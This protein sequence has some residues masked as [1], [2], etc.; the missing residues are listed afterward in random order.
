MNRT[1]W[2]L[3]TLATLGVIGSWV[4]VILGPANLDASAAFS[5]VFGGGDGPTGIIVR[6][7][8]LPRVG[9]TLVAGAG[10]GAAGAMLQSAMRNP[11][12]DPQIFGIGGG[13]AIV[14]ALAIAGVV[15]L[16][17]WGLISLSVVASLGVAAVITLFAIREGMTPARLALV[18][19]SVGA[20]SLAITTA[21]LA[22][23]RVVSSQALALVGGSLANRGWD[24]WIPALTWLFVGTVIAVVISGRINLLALGDNVAANLGAHPR[25]TR[26]AA[27]AAA[28]ILSGA[29]V[30]I[31]GLIGFVGLLAPHMT[32]WLAGHD[33]RTLMLVS[34]PLGAVL[35]LYSDQV[36]RLAVA[37]S[38][39][40]VGLVATVLGA[41]VMIY[42]AR[43]VT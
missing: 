34:P 27:M 17:P 24:S 39:L 4:G 14:Q 41:P 43:W 42:V 19:I 11:L 7:I 12:G 13:A 36:A 8:R 35:T 37:P 23:S 31:A 33:T 32:R 5:A 6:E 1:G 30:T 15:T 25:S 28:G 3:L 26:A 2:L 18:G 40:P 16:G 20:L 10:L 9:A 29:T 22:A 21:L 38:E